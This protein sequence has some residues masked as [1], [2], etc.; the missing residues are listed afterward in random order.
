[1]EKI[2]TRVFQELR[3]RVALAAEFGLEFKIIVSG[4]RRILCVSLSNLHQIP[5][6]IIKLWNPG[7]GIISI[8][9]AC[10]LPCQCSCVIHASIIVACFPGDSFTPLSM[11]LFCLLGLLA[12]QERIDQEKRSVQELSYL[13]A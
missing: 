5:R 12:L 13:L 8:D 2:Q 7:G 10:E 9:P 11:A 3:R 1:M 6:D 4:N